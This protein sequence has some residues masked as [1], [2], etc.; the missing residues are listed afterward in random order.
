MS[1][2]DYLKDN[3]H[4]IYNETLICNKVNNIYLYNLKKSVYLVKINIPDSLIGYTML[5]LGDRTFNVNIN[6]STIEL[7]KNINFYFPNLSRIEISKLKLNDNS[8]TNTP[9]INIQYTL[10]NI[11]KYSNILHS[12]FNIGNYK[13]IES[14]YILSK[15]IINNYNYKLVYKNP[16]NLFVIYLIIKLD[17]FEHNNFD[18]FINEDKSLKD[19][20][21][22]LNYFI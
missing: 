17:K 14:I 7:F 12:S 10:K 9:K 16:N 4:S 13:Q 3:S 5:L 20:I 11:Y 15:K 6:K 18:N 8:L 1:Y 19:I 2:F 21:I 22:Y